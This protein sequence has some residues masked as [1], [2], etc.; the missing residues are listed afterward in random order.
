MKGIVKTND[1]LDWKGHKFR[2]ILGS[3]DTGG[4]MAIIDSISRPGS[5]PPRHIHHAEDEVFVIRTGSCKVWIDGTETTA[6]PGESVFIPR[7][8]EHSFKV[9]GEEPCRHLIIF[10]PG[11]FEGFFHKMAAAQYSIPDD[12]HA[13]TE[14]GAHHNLTFTGPPLD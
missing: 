1:W 13:I 11:G 5:S 7:G 12:M 14:V 3:D 6:G 10:S 8:K 4:V 2:T 9:I